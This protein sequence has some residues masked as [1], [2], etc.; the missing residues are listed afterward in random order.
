MTLRAAGREADLK[1]VA[2]DRHDADELVTY[3]TGAV[4]AGLIDGFGAQGD[5]SLFV[6]TKSGKLSTSIRIGNTGVA[7]SLPRM[8]AACAIPSA[9]QKRADLAQPQTGAL[10]SV[11]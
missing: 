1:V 9:Q 6:D 11:K 8:A 2:S 4:P 5:H 3:A 7:A 10:A